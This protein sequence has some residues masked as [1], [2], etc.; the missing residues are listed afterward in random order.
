LDLKW[1]LAQENSMSYIKIMVHAVWGTK[2][3]QPILEK[4]KREILFE[5]I[6]KNA[7]SKGIY[8]DPLSGYTDH[9]HCLISLG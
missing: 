1:A 6:K 4:S 9:V 5:H 2:Q 7:Y 8:I 3:R